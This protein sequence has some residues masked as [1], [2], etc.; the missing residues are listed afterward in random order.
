MLDFSKKKPIKCIHCKRPQGD[1][2][3][4]TLNCPHYTHGSRTLN[5]FDPEKTFTP[6]TTNPK[7]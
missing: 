7:D 5:F 6:K 2:K 3:A 4:K 1:H